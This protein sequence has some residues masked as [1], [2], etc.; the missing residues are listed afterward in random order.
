[1]LPLFLLSKHNSFIESMEGLRIS[2]AFMKAG[3]S[4]ERQ[5]SGGVTGG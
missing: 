5:G 3:V 2:R 1:M 4:V